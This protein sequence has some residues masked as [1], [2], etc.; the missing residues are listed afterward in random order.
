MRVGNTS[1][2][3]RAVSEHSPLSTAW[4]YT[5]TSGW[6]E[7]EL[8]A[9]LLA[10]GLG[11]DRIRLGWFGFQWR[12]VVG[13]LTAT[14]AVDLARALSRP[15]GTVQLERIVPDDA[16]VLDGPHGVAGWRKGLAWAEGRHITKD[17]RH[18]GRHNLT[19]GQSWSAS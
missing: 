7:R 1:Q 17:D 14:Q 18:P 13:G 10:F 5:L 4:L 8:A 15:D 9:A 2:P 6:T 11:S 12:L 3:Q 19:W 16:P